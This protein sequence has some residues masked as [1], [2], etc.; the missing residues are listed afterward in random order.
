MWSDMN[1]LINHLSIL[2]LTFLDVIMEKV[3]MIPTSDKITN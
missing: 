1:M 2:F 3:E